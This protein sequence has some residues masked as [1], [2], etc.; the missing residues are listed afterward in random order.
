[1]TRTIRHM[2]CMLGA[3]LCMLAITGCNSDDQDPIVIDKGA[4]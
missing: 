2:A 4:Q 3:L 1:M